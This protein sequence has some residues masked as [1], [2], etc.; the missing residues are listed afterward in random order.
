ML[1]KIVSQL[2]L[3][4]G[5]IIIKNDENNIGM[6][7]IFLLFNFSFLNLIQKVYI[8]GNAIYKIPVGL[9]KN[10]NPRVI[11]FEKQ[12][13][14]LFLEFN[15]LNKLKQFKVMKLNCDKSIK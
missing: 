8:Y 10:K 12:Y 1:V 13:S 9:T 5:Q 11:P 3:S 7:N 2:R 4:Q 14:K 15:N 6:K